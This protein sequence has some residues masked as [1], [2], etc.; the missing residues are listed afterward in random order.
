M[1]NSI[2]NKFDRFSFALTI[3]VLFVIMLTSSCG[4]TRHL[5]DNER[6]LRKNEVQLTT[7]QTYA[8]KGALKDAI[9]SVLIQKENTYFL[10]VFPVKG[11]L[12]NLRYNKYQTDTNNFQIRTRIVE[13]PIVF[14]PNA[15]AVSEKQ[16]QTL[17]FNQGYF[18]N[19]V[20]S[21]IDTSRKKVKVTYIVDSKDQ[22]LIDTIRYL[23]DSSF[24]QETMDT[25]WQKN[26]LIQKALPYSNALLITERSNMVNLAKEQG[27][28][29]FNTENIQFELDTTAQ[30]K[31][32]SKRSLV[33]NAA[34]A[35]IGKTKNKRP[36]VSVT[37]VVK[38]QE[39][40]N[41]FDRFRFKNIYVYPEYKENDFHFNR[42]F[43]QD[44][45]KGVIFR[46]NRE[47][48][49]VNRSVI[50]S[51]ITLSPNK[52]YQQSD[53]NNTLIQISELPIF[54]YS[55]IF[56][57]ENN[58][59]V[60][61]DLLDAYVILHQGKTYD[62]NVNYELSGGDLY[63]AGSN[64]STSIINKNL[65]KR[66][67]QL[68]ISANY[69]FE[70]NKINDNS[71]SFIDQFFLM[72][73]NFGL[74]T[75]LVFPAYITPFKVKNSQS[76]NIKTVFNLGVNFLDRTNYFRLNTINS[77]FGYFWKSGPYTT[78]QFNPL[79]FN[80]LNLSRISDTFQVRL[81]TVQ[82]IRN[83]YQENFILGE[84]FEFIHN[85]EGKL[86][87]RY[88][89][90]RLGIEE[91]G[92]LLH[93][94]NGVSK[95][96]NA[97]GI[98][99][100]YSNYVRFDF[101]LRQY[102]LRMNSSWA[103]RL[104]GGV[105]VPYGGRKTLPYIKQYFV[106]GAYSI[107]GWGPRLLGPGSYYNATQQNASNKLFIDQSGDIKLEF[108]AE[109]RFKML[110]LFAGAIGLNG[111]FFVD[112]GNIWLAHLEPNLPGANFTFKNLYQDIAVSP[113]FGLRADLGGFLVLRA[114]WA[115]ALKKPYLTEN[116]GWMFDNLKIGS[117]AWRSENINLNIGIG[118]PF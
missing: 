19:Q 60:G 50:R 88:H 66:A 78:F 108:N 15:V 45:I 5:E 83:A 101:D 2:I 65:F 23:V 79:F 26:S 99:F 110:Q 109:Y 61:A 36:T 114:D 18:N 17:L 118:L 32:K 46:Y 3:G 7:S 39:D 57:V 53:Y 10:G 52:I 112:A 48:A 11:W 89:F 31:I 49:K 111:A 34:D 16:I 42:F 91:S 95:M 28:Y 22:Y 69:G 94:V 56:I 68:S 1:F 20:T 25:I 44:T 75:R 67:N 84:N 72:S 97:D 35:F 59:E 33:E 6:L 98:N 24:F 77:S 14:D 71:L 107:R 62:F 64:I 21:K 85:T 74:N 4:V 104:H 113:G 73:Q 37:A 80:S 9:T 100:N 103:F 76:S 117:K 13:K 41:S 27:F 30:R 87:N 63:L 102:F 47:R 86:N 38:K 55:R 58:E 70:L 115:I 106:G 81:D 82:A 51:K 93:G 96:F 40:F 8:N 116:H 43:Y 90:I 29:K 105:G 92:A 12:Y 54:N